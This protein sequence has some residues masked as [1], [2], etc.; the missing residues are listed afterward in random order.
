MACHRTPLLHDFIAIFCTQIE[1]PENCHHCNGCHLMTSERENK[2][3]TLQRKVA[4]YQSTKGTTTTKTAITYM[5]N[6]IA[7]SKM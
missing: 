7:S 5:Y 6:N 2:Q 3:K 4:K 1:N